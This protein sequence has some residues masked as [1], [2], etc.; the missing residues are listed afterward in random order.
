MKLGE[1]DID[2]LVV[3]AAYNAVIASNTPKKP[4]MVIE[5]VDDIPSNEAVTTRVAAADTFV[6]RFGLQGEDS[7]G[8]IFVNGKYFELTEVGV[9]TV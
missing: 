7:A 4:E 5:N 6:Q 8:A 9:C 3:T 1:G 2:P